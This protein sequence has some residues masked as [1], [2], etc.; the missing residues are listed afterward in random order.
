MS[1]RLHAVPAGSFS[2]RVNVR[3]P[4]E[5]I[6]WARKEIE[7]AILQH[8]KLVADHEGECE[9]EPEEVIALGPSLRAALWS[10]LN[11]QEDLRRMAA[12]S[13]REAAEGVK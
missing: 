5:V 10:V 8:A 11:V 13:P 2:R 1:R 4:L 6:G 7:Q 12:A 9:M 3:D